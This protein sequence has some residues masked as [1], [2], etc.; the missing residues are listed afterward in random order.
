MI[1]EKSII[2]NKLETGEYSEEIFEL[3][4]NE[5][6]GDTLMEKFSSIAIEIAY[7]SRNELHESNS[8]NWIYASPKIT[9]FFETSVHFNSDDYCDYDTDK[10]LC[11]FYH[12]F[13]V[14]WFVV[15]N[16]KLDNKSEFVVGSS[17]NES[18]LCKF[19]FKNL[20]Y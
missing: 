14:K 18:R 20:H 2:I 10:I 3:D 11:G 9:C 1:T 17:D 6:I 4:F 7:K 19:V 16:K 8:F 13:D 12:M 15:K 5:L